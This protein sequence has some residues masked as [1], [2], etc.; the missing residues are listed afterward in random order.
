M[1][2]LGFMTVALGDKYEQFVAPYIAS[3][4]LTY[5]EATTEIRVNAPGKWREKHKK[6][7]SKLT[8]LFGDRYRVAKVTYPWRKRR[9]I[10]NSVRFVIRP[11]LSRPDLLYIGDVD[12]MISAADLVTFHTQAMTDLKLPYSNI[13]RPGTNRLTGLHAVATEAYYAKITPA[14]VEVAVKRWGKGNDEKLLY[15]LC[16][17]NIGLPKKVVQ[18]PVFGIHASPQRPAL[19]TVGLPCHWGIPLHFQ[20]HIK[21]TA[22]PEWQELAPLF[23]APFQK[24]LSQVDTWI[25]KHRE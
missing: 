25:Q 12:I 24:R 16:R 21:L 15:H 2:T 23:T 4:L 11:E 5:P 3:T 8:A 6:L 20:D 22:R 7:A 10:P 19:E 9:L 18:R 14:A 13:I 1:T 17:T